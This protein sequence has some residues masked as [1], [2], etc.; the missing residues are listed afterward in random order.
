MS[1]FRKGDVRLA[2]YVQPFYPMDKTIEKA[3]VAKIKVNPSTQPLTTM[4]D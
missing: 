4:T 3:T 1:I 2:V